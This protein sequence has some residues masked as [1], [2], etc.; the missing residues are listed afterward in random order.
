MAYFRSIGFDMN[1]KDADGKTPLHHAL[2]LN[3]RCVMK[4]MTNWSG[5][6]YNA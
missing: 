6:D 3:S 1:P 4:Y 5:V 2:E